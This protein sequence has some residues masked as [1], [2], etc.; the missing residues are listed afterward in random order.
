MDT[1][2]QIETYHLLKKQRELIEDKMKTLRDKIIA[3]LV[4]DSHRVDETTFTQAASSARAS[5]K[6][7]NVSAK[8]DDF[9]LMDLLEKKGL[10]WCLKQVPDHSLVEQ[11]YIEGHLSD[12][13]LRSVQS[14]KEP[15]FALSTE[16]IYV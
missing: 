15:S 10:S 8:L 2:T 6:V 1:L 14:N 4:N 11:A 7:K 12:E 16:D 5:V 9:A 3:A 13:D